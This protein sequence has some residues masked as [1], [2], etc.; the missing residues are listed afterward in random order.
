V[1][2]LPLFLRQKTTRRIPSA[3]LLVWSAVRGSPSR[4]ARFRA[5]FDSYNRGARLVIPRN[6]EGHMAEGVELGASPSPQ[7]DLHA[8][9]PRPRRRPALIAI[10]TVVIVIG[11]TF[12]VYEV[13]QVTRPGASPYPPPPPGWVTFR[14]AWADVS[15]D[16]AD[17]AQGPWTVAF[18]EGVAADAPW[19]PPISIFGVNPGCAKELSGISTLTYW[20]SSAYPYSDSPNVYSS[21]AAPLWTFVFNGTGTPAF[22]A[23]WVAGQ[24]VDNA[25]LEPTSPCIRFGDFYASPS[26]SIRPSGVADSDAIP[27]AVRATTLP[28]L[29]WYFPAPGFPQPPSPFFAA[30][31]LS[32]S[33]LPAIDGNANRWNVDYGE[34]GMEGQIG[35][36]FTMAE[37]QFNSSDL[38]EPSESAVPLYPCFDSEYLLEMNRT[39]IVTPPSPSGVYLEWTLNWSFISSAVPPKWTASDLNT[40]LIQWEIGPPGI[41]MFPGWQPSAAVCGAENP[42][43]ANCMPPSQGWYVVLLNSNGS[44]LDSY[45]TVANGTAWSIPSVSLSLG[46]RIVFVGAAGNANGNLLWVHRAEEP[47]VFLEEESGSS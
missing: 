25:V 23:S 7:A 16:F 44:W 40:S 14:T 1:G 36:N 32:S 37:F 12:S 22:V 18:A 29:N 8:G 5:E 38:E 19:S 17:L 9:N 34:C 41:F 10:I 3:P 46:D 27:A 2:S 45:P 31:F 33:V 30:Y 11:A 26:L 15:G 24:V 35:S 28:P 39:T 43:F 42:G 21:G 6:V 4:Y 20:N 13:Y 47:A